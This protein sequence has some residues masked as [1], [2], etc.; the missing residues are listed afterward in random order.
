MLRHRITGFLLFLV[1]LSASAAFCAQDPAPPPATEVSQTSEPEKKEPVNVPADRVQRH[2]QPA[3]RRGPDQGDVHVAGHPPV[4]VSPLERRHRQ[5]L[6]ARQR[7]RLGVR[8]LVRAHQEPEHRVLPIVAER[9]VRG[10][11]SVRVAAMVRIQ[12]VSAGR[13]R[14]AHHRVDL[15]PEELL[16]AGGPR[17]LLRPLCADHRRSD[18]PAADLRRALAALVAPPGGRVLPVDWR[19]PAVVHLPW[20]LPRH[21]QRAGG[22]FGRHHPFDHRSTAR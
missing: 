14:L 9:H 19:R 18:L 3:V 8:S 15:P 5:F 16:R 4:H 21:V 10:V 7:Q 17:V 12:C 2:H 1:G 22:R 13:G 20:D 11:R 6:H